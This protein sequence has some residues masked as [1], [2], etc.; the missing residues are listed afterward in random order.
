MSVATELGL[1]S[2]TIVDDCYC[3]EEEDMRC[4]LESS[5]SLDDVM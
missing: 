1:I 4:C 3:T 5:M 2:T